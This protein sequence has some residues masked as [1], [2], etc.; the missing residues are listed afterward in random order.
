[1]QIAVNVYVYKYLYKFLSFSTLKKYSLRRIPSSQ[2]RNITY[3][4]YM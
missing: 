2:D 1:M 4:Q 3:I